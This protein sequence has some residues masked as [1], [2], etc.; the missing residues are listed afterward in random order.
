MCMRMCMCRC[1]CV[2]IH[3]HTH[4][5]I[6][7]KT[8]TH[9]HTRKTTHTHTLTSAA[10]S[11]PSAAGS[12]RPT[13]LTNLRPIESP[14]WAHVAHIIHSADLGGWSKPATDPLYERGREGERDFIRK[15][16]PSGSFPAKP[17]SPGGSGSNPNACAAMANPHFR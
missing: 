6:H 11:A 4:T 2:C 3:T 17:T 10:Y 12:G 7:T 14:F 1:V 8:H 9:K 15:Q 13:H 5:Q 16:C